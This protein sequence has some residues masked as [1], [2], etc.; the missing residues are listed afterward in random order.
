MARREW[1]REFSQAPG[2]WLNNEVV[3]VTAQTPTVNLTARIPTLAEVDGAPFVELHMTYVVVDPTVGPRGEVSDASIAGNTAHASYFRRPVTA[4]RARV[5]IEKLRP[6]ANAAATALLDG[7]W[8]LVYNDD[9]NND[10]N[11]TIAVK[12][13]S[14][15]WR[16]RS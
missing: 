13:P 3:A 4:G 5:V 9:A 12:V 15:N 2:V 6:R 11:V 7:T 10:Y 16:N 14:L 8:V 1:S